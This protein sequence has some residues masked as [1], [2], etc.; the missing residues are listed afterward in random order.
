MEALQMK[1]LT[2]VVRESKTCFINLNLGKFIE[3]I[4]TFMQLFVNFLFCNALKNWG[5]GL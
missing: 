3:H 2:R 4:L 5:N 1:K